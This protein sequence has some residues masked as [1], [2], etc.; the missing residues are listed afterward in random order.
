MKRILIVEDNKLIRVA[1]KEAIKR[2]DF[3]IL[4]VENGKQALHKFE[5]NHLDLLIMDIKMPDIDGLQVLKKIRVVNKELPI[6]IISAYKNLGKDPEIA[7]GNVSAFMAKPIDIKLLKA[8]VTEILEGKMI[9]K[10]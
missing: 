6:I 9:S 4:E 10:V 5:E 2:E 7:L 3:E 1:L 8:K